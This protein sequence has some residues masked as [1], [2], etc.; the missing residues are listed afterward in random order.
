MSLSLASSVLLAFRLAISFNVKDMLAVI[1][2]AGG[3][4]SGK[5]GFANSFITFPF[6]SCT[7]S[8]SFLFF[9]TNISM[10]FW[11]NFNLKYPESSVLLGFTNIPDIG[12]RSSSH[13]DT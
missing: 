12:F 9:L 8:L 6:S 13:K 4:I 7:M 3:G 2:R 10:S 11:V 5:V 1:R